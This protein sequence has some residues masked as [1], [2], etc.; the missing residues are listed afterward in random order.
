[1][2][3]LAGLCSRASRACRAEKAAAFV[4]HVYVLEMQK[5]WTSFLYNIIFTVFKYSYKN[6]LIQHLLK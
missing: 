5:F 2:W 4:G 6:I 3:A 1:M